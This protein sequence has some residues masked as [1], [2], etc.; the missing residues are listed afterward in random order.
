MR[1]SDWSFILTLAVTLT[2]ASRVRAEPPVAAGG[3]A[4]PCDP[5]QQE[6][7]VAT[8]SAGDGW[9]VMRKR[10]PTETGATLSYRI[11]NGAA[12]SVPGQKGAT[13]WTF[14][15]AEKV[16]TDAFVKLEFRVLGPLTGAK[17]A[18]ASKAL[19][20]FVKALESAVKRSFDRAVEA[21][22]GARAEGRADLLAGAFKS[23][24]R[25]EV[26]KLL[27]A[28]ALE[29]Y[30]YDDVRATDVVLEKAGFTRL[31]EG[32]W[33]PTAAS[34]E[35]LRQASLAPARALW[36]ARAELENKNVRAA[37]LGDASSL[38]KS[39]EAAPRERALETCLAS[40]SEAGKKTAVALSKDVEFKK[41]AAGNDPS[42]LQLLAGPEQDLLQVGA[43]AAFFQGLKAADAVSIPSL[44]SPAP[45]AAGA[46]APPAGGE[47]TSGLKKSVEDA[48]VR[49]LSAASSETITK[50]D[51]SI[52]QGAV[53]A[54]NGVK[55][56]V[57]LL[58]DARLRPALAQ[59]TVDKFVPT[60]A[61]LQGLRTF[62]RAGLATEFATV[63]RPKPRFFVSTGVVATWLN[64]QHSDPWKLSLPVLVSV[65]WSPF[66]CET[67]G[68]GMGGNAATY[69]SFDLGV[70]TIFLGERD[71]REAAPSFL[72]GLGFTPFYATHVS[73]GINV[74]DN[75]QPPQH[76]HVNVGLYTSVTLDVISGGDI[77]GA[78]GLAKP[79]PEVLGRKEK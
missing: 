45:P 41:K 77:L 62:T 35:N 56:V 55:Y 67:K 20:E 27:A 71:P 51:P 31:G 75:P 10:C 39:E 70:K 66:G 17:A 63:S 44:S 1:Y 57:A 49:I 48:S 72:A 52:K 69:V 40:L 3:D 43:A 78:I 59:Q 7:E 34:M 38:V 61:A 19:D 13:G 12:R 37:C 9:I 15:I 58:V 79:E 8:A 53:D 33:E 68:I 65:C 11:G 50:I 74:F 26:G 73:V 64:G 47:T 25:A 14:G 6:V 21:T 23:E 32:D 18:K 22:Q 2:L 54:N 5:E 76:G 29:E 28:T 36:N 42:K 16:P 46:S 4:V 60:D 24:A 30:Y